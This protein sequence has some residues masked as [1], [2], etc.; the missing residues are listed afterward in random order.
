MPAR[1]PEHT[2]F[3]N[4]QNSVPNPPRA[5]RPKSTKT[6]SNAHGVGVFGT[7]GPEVEIGPPAREINREVFWRRRGGCSFVAPFSTRI[8][9]DAY[10]RARRA[11]GASVNWARLLLRWNGFVISRAKSSAALGRFGRI[12]YRGGAASAP[13]Q[14]GL[15]VPELLPNWQL[16]Q[17]NKAIPAP[18][19]AS[20]PALAAHPES[21]RRSL[22]P[23]SSAAAPG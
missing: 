21:P 4:P 18:T 2:P 15:S 14:P 1:P 3:G 16:I 20:F 23:V 19:A 12:V 17:P 22:A 11:A 9:S 6:Q 5:A 10:N 13:L 8:R 7:Q